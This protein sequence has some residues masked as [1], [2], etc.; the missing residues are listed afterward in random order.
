MTQNNREQH[1]HKSDRAVQQIL[2]LLEREYS[3]THPRAKLEVYRHGKYS[4]RIRII[5]QEF[6]GT[7]I[8]RRGESIWRILRALPEKIFI[9]ISLLL[10]LAPKETKTSAMNQDFEDREPAWLS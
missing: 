1:D 10:L 9:Q 6:A 2:Q 4:I 3:P 7:S 5:D 8:F